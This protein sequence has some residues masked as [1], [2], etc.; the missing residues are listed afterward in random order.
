MGRLKTFGQKPTRGVQQ[1]WQRGTQ[2]DQGPR[3]VLPPPP[4]VPSSQCPSLRRAA[5]APVH[6]GVHP[7]SLGS[8]QLGTALQAGGLTWSSWGQLLHKD[9]PLPTPAPKV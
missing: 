3:G 4:P 7:Y 9:S 8:R 2:E 6:S 1:L 5:R